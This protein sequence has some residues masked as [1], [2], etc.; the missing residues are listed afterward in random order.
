MRHLGDSLRIGSFPQT[1]VSL[2]LAIVLTWLLAPGFSLLQIPR[3]APLLFEALVL[4]GLV[5]L[6]PIVNVAQLIRGSSTFRMRDAVLRPPPPAGMNGIL[7]EAPAKPPNLPLRMTDGQ[8]LKFHLKLRRVLVGASIGALVLALLLTLVAL[9]LLTVSPLVN[10]AVILPVWGAASGFV[11]RCTLPVLYDQPFF[12]DEA[13]FTPRPLPIR[14]I[15]RRK[16]L[17]RYDEISACTIIRRHMVWS[18]GVQLKDGS[19]LYMNERSGIPETAF[20]VLATKVPVKNVV[21]ED[22]SCEL[23]AGRHLG[24]R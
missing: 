16:L 15:L 10:I 12:M 17:L 7:A 4:L 3:D 24:S 1:V 22:S 23:D 21:T 19:V 6:L 20:G 11:I 13:G 2:L 18:A 5:W 8:F 9:Q 14:F